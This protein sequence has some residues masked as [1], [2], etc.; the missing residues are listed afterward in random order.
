MTAKLIDTHA[1]LNFS[2]FINDPLPFLDRAQKAGVAAIIVPGVDIPS[3]EKAINLAENHP[4]VFAAVG[5][6]PEESKTYMPQMRTVLESLCTHE[7]CVAIGEI[8]MDFYR[9]YASEEIQSRAFYDQV[10][11]A[12]SL[13]LP[14]IIHNRK[15]DSYIIRILKEVHY[16]QGQCHCF[17]SHK[18]F[19]QECLEYGLLLSFTGLITFAEEIRNVALTLPPEK[20]MIETD[21]PFMAPVPYRG[22]TNEPAY[23]LKVAEAYA[24]L[25]NLPFDEVANTTTRNA[26][27]LFSKLTLHE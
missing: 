27:S 20:L 23:V 11:L 7:K 26:L 13:H 2:P 1:H 14:M 17:T 12:K 16:F 3:S 21:S 22:K 25:F 19:A 15:A 24:N 10:E 4:I 8:G 18:T 9:E 6:H 5:I